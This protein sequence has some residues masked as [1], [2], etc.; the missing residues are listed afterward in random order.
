ML[1][2][3]A[4]PVVARVGPSFTLYTLLRTHLE[5]VRSAGFQVTCIC[6]DDEWAERI[7]ALGVKVVP[8]GMGRRPS[9][10]RLLGWSVHLYRHL[11]REHVDILHTSNAFHGVAARAVGRCARVPVVVHTV[12]NW[13]YLQSGARHR[14]FYSMLERLG[15]A[16]ADAVFFVG[17]D[18]WATAESRRLVPRRKRVFIGDG[19]DVAG[20]E[21]TVAGARRAGMRDSLGLAHD[22]I[23]VAM[24]ARTEPPKDQDLLVEAFEVLAGSRPRLH[25]VLI[26]GGFGYRSVEARAE[27]SAFSERVHLLGHRT[28]VPALLQGVDVLVLA[29]SYEA[30]GRSLVEGMLAR[31]PVVGCDVPGIRHVIANGETGLLVRYG[32]AGELA[33]AIAAVLD[34]PELAERLTSAAFPRAVARFD[35]A[36]VSRRVCH[37]Y[38]A[39]LGARGRNAHVP[40]PAARLPHERFRL[41]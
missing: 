16:L 32:D 33:G 21:R 37:A 22:D 30:F 5:D 11:R 26:G 25:L 15:G 2:S 29:S 23:V 1:D 41:D 34:D 38:R 6:D 17:L 28:D 12:H 8:L 19:V 4:G 10:A 20:F 7:R 40:G 39:L 9:P 36:D 14:R 18:D 13:F 24:V 27:T 31:V 35:E 3:A